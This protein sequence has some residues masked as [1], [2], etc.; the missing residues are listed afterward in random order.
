MTRMEKV[1]VDEII[2]KQEIELKV[3]ELK[4]SVAEKEK[5]LEKYIAENEKLRLHNQKLYSER[6]VGVIEKEEIKEEEPIEPKNIK[7]L[8]G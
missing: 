7:G 5:E 1:K 4:L 3:E 2:N 6:V 8:W